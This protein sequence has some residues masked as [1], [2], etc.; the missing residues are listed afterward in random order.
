MTGRRRLQ[1][2]AVAAVVLAIV[3]PPIRYALRRRRGDSLQDL[4]RAI[5]LA[6]HGAAKAWPGYD[7]LDQPLLVTL[8]PDGA[9]LFGTSRLPPG[10]T[11]PSWADTQLAFTKR[12]FLPS[13][14]F[15]SFYSLDGATVTAQDAGSVWDGKK[16]SL[17]F[18][19]EV[20]HRYQA[21][22]F[23]EPQWRHY[24]VAD[25]ADVALADAEESSLAAWLE[26]G[27]EDAMRDFAAVRA[28]RRRRF[29]GSAV[30][31]G[32]ERIE[33]TAQFVEWAALA[34][35]SSPAA[36]RERAVAKLR[37]G[38]TIFNMAKWRHYA[39][40]ATL[41]RWLDQEKVP[42]WRRA[43]ADGRAPSDLVLQR[44]ALGDAEIKTR[45]ARLTAT[46]AYARALQG[47][48]GAI[49]LWDRLRK[50]ALRQFAALP[51]RRLLLTGEA[52]EA[53][54]DGFWYDYP[55]DSSLLIANRWL[56]DRPKIRVRL[57]DDKGI[58]R[59]RAAGKPTAEFVV[60]PDAAVTLNGARWDFHPGRCEFQTLSISSAP[61]VSLTAG[62]GVLDDDGR[63]VRLSFPD[64]R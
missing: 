13:T 32:E 8:G 55:D 16:M 44:L 41:C 26:R 22:A 49:A 60:P 30:E 50:E 20:F 64:A 63:T 11:R 36:A 5:V 57:G 17:Y 51:G 42:D 3:V 56:V 34:V 2:A 31:R 7:P 45:I 6:D 37:G 25:P 52:A 33:G 43:V 27:D 39:I 24:P 21:R 23:D 29:P 62:P 53:G 10:F 18:V 58:M 46:P 1:A 14:P 4:A 15:D 38:A 61:R 28:E 47:A 59:R 40:G 12:T 19:H 35:S 48:K 9:L 54:F